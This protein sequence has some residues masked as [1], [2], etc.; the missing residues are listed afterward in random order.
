MITKKFFIQLKSDL[1]VGSGFS[2]A[3]IVDSD[4][5]YNKY[6]FPYISGKRLKGCMRESAELL[7]M[8]D[9]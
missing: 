3:G 2:Y 6:G 4:V 7:G 5:S 1:C 8:T 9:D